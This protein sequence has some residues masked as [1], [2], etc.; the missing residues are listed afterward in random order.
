MQGPKYFK[1]YFK[2]ALVPGLRFALVLWS[3]AEAR[4]KFTITLYTA[5]KWADMH[6]LFVF[7]CFWLFQLPRSRNES[8]VLRAW[9]FEKL[10]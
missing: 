8:A 7:S 9:L 4:P 1:L 10:S 5:Q 3:Q 6:K 2:R